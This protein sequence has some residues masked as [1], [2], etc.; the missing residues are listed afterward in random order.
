MSVSSL[1]FLWF[2]RCRVFVPDDLLGP[3]NRQLIAMF[4]QPEL[5]K[6]TIDRA[7]S[8]GSDNRKHTRLRPPSLNDFDFLHYCRA[9]NCR[10]CWRAM[11]RERFYLFVTCRH[12]PWPSHRLTNI[13]NS[14]PSEPDAGQRTNSD[15]RHFASKF[16]Q[17][18]V[19][20]SFVCAGVLS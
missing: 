5:L 6:R 9:I 13:L 7:T 2:Y 14:A 20:R 19:I 8:K 1:H 10:Q 4:A 17:A 3:V 16:S 11:Y 15:R 18:A 12:D